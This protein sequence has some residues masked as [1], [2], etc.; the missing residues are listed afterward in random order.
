MSEKEP[1]D[2]TTWNA[3]KKAIVGNIE[4]T[5]ESNRKTLDMISATQF[6]LGEAAKYL[7][8]DQIRLAQME[9]VLTSEAYVPNNPVNAGSID[10]MNSLSAN[11][12]G[13]AKYMASTA[14]VLRT[15]ADS[16][17]GSTITSGSI[18]TSMASTTV[19]L[20]DRMIDTEPIAPVIAELRKPTAQERLAELS[21]R[22]SEIGKELSA[23][24]NGAWETL[25]NS[26]N[27]DRVSQASHSARELISDILLRLAPDES[28][29]EMEW[30]KPDTPNGRPTQ[31]QRAK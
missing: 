12:L 23:K 5:I 22:L 28:V 13:S 7:T 20:A 21:P 16:L 29:M 27:D 11:A 1:A 19:Y 6:K 10:V 30:F 24:L 2:K 4:G 25:R 15:N 9:K 3:K 18:V 26:S 17:T 8:N 14:R 31:R